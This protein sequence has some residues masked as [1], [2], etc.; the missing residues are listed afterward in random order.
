MTRHLSWTAC[1]VIHCDAD[2]GPVERHA[3][4]ELG[5][6]LNLIVPGAGEG[7][8]PAIRLRVCPAEGR[9]D[10]AF[11]WRHDAEGFHIEG[12]GVLGLIFG[13]YAFLRDAVGCRFSAPGPDGEHV[14]RLCA[15]AVPEDRAM[16][17]PLLSYRTIQ[18][19]YQD[20]EHLMHGQIDWAVK[21]GLNYVTY[22]LANNSPVEGQVDPQSGISLNAGLMQN[23]Y[24]QPDYF[25]GRLLAFIQSRGMKLDFSHHNLLYWLPP[26][27]YFK[28]HPEW[29]ML[30]DG[31][32]GKPFSQLAICTSND[33]AVNEVIENIRG[34]I[35]AHPGIDL[36]GVIPE[37][38]IGMC[39]CEACVAMDG[40]VGDASK[41]YRGHMAPDARNDS[42]SARYGR[43]L[44]RV[45]EALEGE[46][47]HVKIPA[48]AYVDLQWPA[49]GITLHKNIVV[50]LALYWRDGARP[51]YSEESGEAN[52][53]FE[54]IIEE[55]NEGIRGRLGLYEYY[56]GM[57]AQASLPY[58]MSQV[59]LEDWKQL[60]ARDVRG[61]SIQC[62]CTCHHA[63]GLNMLA[64]ARAGW[65]GETDHGRLMDD[66]LLGEF[67]AAG[68]AVRPVYKAW[69]R[70]ARAIAARKADSKGVKCPAGIPEWVLL[71][72]LENVSYFMEGMS[73]EFVAGVLLK[74]REACGCAR[75]RRQVDRLA[76]YLRYCRGADR[77]FRFLESSAGDEPAGRAERAHVLVEE[78][79]AA[80]GSPLA[81]GWIEPIHANHYKRRLKALERR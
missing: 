46:F 32:R 17:G 35:R 66:Y 63:Y 27:K 65:E 81:E 24:L 64:F 53:A 67:G 34:Y 49:P 58:P 9:S 7:G 8:E 11:G 16:A 10:E 61:A 14:P 57:N 45:A 30:V 5:R 77:F 36:V 70:Q 40:A 48:V 80:M 50:G 44:N 22:L 4:A 6:Y 79:L 29:Y 78:V 3:A 25:H 13:V 71:P 47:P 15:L 54:G 1:P 69:E 59:I 39:Q 12:G 62:N 18:L 60:R 2:C 19:S 42:K 56:M 52:R 21:N 26:E 28:A 74:A 43:L 76:N 75:E 20:P 37:D 73:E 41:P 23:T 51:V 55:W 31:V 68:M 38:G 72:T 33:D